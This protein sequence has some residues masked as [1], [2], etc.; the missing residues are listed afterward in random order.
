[1]VLNCHLLLQSQFLCAFSFIYCL[2]FLLG[3]T[4]LTESKLSAFEKGREKTPTNF[5]NIWFIFMNISKCF[6]G[7]VYKKVLSLKKFHLIFIFIKKHSLFWR[8]LKKSQL[9]SQ[10]CTDSQSIL[11]H[12]NHV[13]LFICLL[14]THKFILNLCVKFPQGSNL[15]T[16]MRATFLR[17]TGL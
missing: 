2:N 12:S 4:H 6:E 1:M 13:E 10:Q 14:H 17:K 15:F 16:F 3:K 5:T 7:E 8:F 9:S 11:F